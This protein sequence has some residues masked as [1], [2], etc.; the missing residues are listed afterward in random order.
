MRKSRLIPASAVSSTHIDTTSKDPLPGKRCELNRSMQHYLINW[1]D[2]P[3][4]PEYD[5]GGQ[6]LR[7][8]RPIYAYFETTSCLWNFDSSNVTSP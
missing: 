4:L 3:S 7:L 8:T 6:T 2:K 1:S 5:A